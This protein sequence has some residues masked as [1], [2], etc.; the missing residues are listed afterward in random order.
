MAFLQAVGTHQ[1]DVRPADREDA[2]RAPRG[3]ADRG[4]VP[5]LRGVGVGSPGRYGARCAATATG[6]TPGPPPP[7]GMQNVLCRLRW[8]TSPPSSPGPRQPD[9]RVEVRA[10]DVDLPAGLVH[11]VADR[12]HALLVD[13]VRRGVGDHDRGHL[14]A[15]LVQLGAQVVEVDRAVDGRGDDDDAHARE[16]RRRRV[17]AVRARRDQA[18]VTLVAA[19]RVVAVDGQQPG[20]L[21]LR[22]RVRLHRHRRVA[23]DLRQPVLQLR[24]QLGVA[25]RSGR[26]GA[27]GWM[28][29]NSG[30]LIGSISA[31]AL[32]FMVHEPSGI[33]VRSRARSL[34]E[35]RRR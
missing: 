32:S 19:R 28:V 17:G 10:V 27:Y 26:A 8:Q 16:R 29:A 7:C 35:R 5:S 3:G 31:V 24:H 34:S 9:Q 21:A 14:R 25:L 4:A 30:Q 6:P 22:A 1:R 13:A 23:R 11:E 33:I 12:A 15:V 20:Q 2:G 18:D